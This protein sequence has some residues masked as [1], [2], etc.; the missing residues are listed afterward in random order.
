MPTNI[1]IEVSDLAAI[2]KVL[3]RCAPGRPA[4]L[5]GSR[6]TGL[7]RPD[8]DLDIAIGGECPLTFR[9]RGD[10][11]DA[12]D[13]IGLGYKVD[14]IDLHDARGIFRKRIEAEWIPLEEAAGS[15]SKAIA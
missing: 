5:F 6:V 11:R 8:S 9:E 4:F 1:S 10:M 15:G 14:V 13:E 3:Q 2:G 12:L 7:A